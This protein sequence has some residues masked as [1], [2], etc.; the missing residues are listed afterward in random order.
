MLR[1]HQD[2]SHFHKEEE[3]E[4]K[5]GE[6]KAPGERGRREEKTGGHREEGN[7]AG[8]TTDWPPLAPPPAAVTRGRSLTTQKPENHQDSCRSERKNKEMTSDRVFVYIAVPPL[9]PGGVFLQPIKS[10]RL[11]GTVQEG[12]GGGSGALLAFTHA[13]CAVKY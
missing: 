13:V 2:V 7:E 3:E 12:R 9:I 11:R 8:E 1:V 5:D 6:M 4:S 10:Q